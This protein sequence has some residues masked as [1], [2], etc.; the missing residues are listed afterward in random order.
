[1]IKIPI[2][3]HSPA[4]GQ[5]M[6]AYD[7]YAETKD[8][9]YMRSRLRLFSVVTRVALE[10]L[11]ATAVENRG[12]QNSNTPYFPYSSLPRFISPL[13][14]PLL[15]SYS[16][17]GKFQSWEA[18]VMAVSCNRSIQISETITRVPMGLYD[19]WMCKQVAEAE[20][21][22]CNYEYWAGMEIEHGIEV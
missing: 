18:L 5:F 17:H 20:Q 19:V 12:G 21:S 14:T 1:M 15:P 22:P 2:P 10:N 16:S 4:R 7:R 9:W 3:L 8:V 13:A 6:F 11:N